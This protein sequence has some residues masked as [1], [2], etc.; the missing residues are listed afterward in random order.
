MSDGKNFFLNV[1]NSASGQAWVDRL[2]RV[3]RNNALAISQKYGLADQ[4]ARV[5]SGR[6]VDEDDA[7]AFLS[8]TLKSLMPDP[9]CLVDME[10]AAARI[11]EAIEKRE[12]VAVFGDYDVDGAASAALLARFLHFFSVSSRIYIPDRLVEGYGPNP[13]AMRMLVEEGMSLIVT[14]DCGANSPEAI[15]AARVAGGD[16]VVLDHHQMGDSVPD[17]ANALVNP[18]RPDDLSGQGHLCA[19]GVVFLTLVEVSRQLRVKGKQTPDLLALLDLVALATVCDVVPLTGLNRAF[20]VKGLQVA[21]MQ[22]NQGLNALSKVAKIDAPLNS[23]HFGYVLGPRINAGG[24]IGNQALGAQLL[25]TNSP[26]EA[27]RIAV[28]LNRLNQERQVIEAVQLEEAEVH[29]ALD[30]D[31]ADLPSAL[32]VASPDW[33]PGIIGLLAARLKERFSRPVFA[34]AL[35]AD[36]TGSGSGRSVAGLDIGA[37]VRQAVDEGILEKGGGHSMAAGLTIRAD[38]VEQ[39]KHW[40]Q[41]KTAHKMTQLHASRVL[42]VDGILSASGATVELVELLEQAGPFGAG[43]PPPVFVVPEHRLVHV[44]EVGTGHLSLEVVGLDGVRLKA[45]AF[46]AVGTELGNFLLDNRGNSIH[47]AGSLA[48]N[49][50]NGRVSPQLRVLD[51][52]FP[53]ARETL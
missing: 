53:S 52:A 22:N 27:E 42:N 40:L 21:R 39:F 46:R 38:H 33:H 14:V 30:G 15:T 4:L 24:R 2:D 41:D 8:P 17:A 10:K 48:I 32:V 9:R 28:E 26:D 36:G 7:T 43:N 31:V 29:L 3:G 50:W 45:I 13:Q 20:V 5:L 25:S 6:G 51:A 34:I 18:N 23:F 16:V 11:V 37:L 49:H 35:K 12:H 44:R 1:E 47:L 19:A